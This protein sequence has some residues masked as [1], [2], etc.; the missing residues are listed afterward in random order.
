MY[1]ERY[2]E[3]YHVTDYLEVVPAPKPASRRFKIALR[4]T[5]VLA[6]IS[7]IASLLYF[8]L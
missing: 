5:I 3:R 7:V 4:V 1:P 6:T 8:I 2:Y